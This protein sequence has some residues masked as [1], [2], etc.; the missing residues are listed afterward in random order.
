M[1][2]FTKYKG[3]ISNSGGDERGGIKSGKAGDQTGNEWVVRSWY[4]RP[5]DCVLRHPDT[6]VRELIAELAIEAANNN[7]IGY[8]QG[9][10][11]TYWEQLQKVGYRPKNITTPCEAD[12]SAGVIANTKSAGSILGM[13]KLRNIPATYT[14]NM[15]NAYKDAGFEVLTD[16]KY[17]TSADYLLPGDILLADKH[18]TA[19]NL[20][21]GSKAVA[22]NPNG[23]DIASYQASLDP[24][25]I[26]GDFI[27]VKATQGTGYINP[28]FEKHA[29][30]T[31]KS[32]KVLGLYHYANGSGVT[33]EVNF[34][35]QT[36]EK[37]IGKAFLCLDWENI[38]VAGENK[39][40]K[41]PG[42]AKQFMDEVR[43]RT[44]LTM[45][46][47]GSKDSCFNAMDWSAVKG[48][49]YPLWGAQYANYN[50]VNGYDRNPWES[51]RPWG[52]WGR[53]VAIHQYTS[54][55]R[56]PGY[57]GN[58]D[59]DLSHISISA[60]EGYTIAGTTSGV[61]SKPTGTLDRAQLLQMVAD[62]MGGKYGTNDERKKKL[63]GYYDQVQ[64]VIN[65]VKKT[66]VDQLADDVISGKFG[67]TPIREKVLGDKYDDV[68]KSVNAKLKK[69]KTISQLAKEVLE[70]KWGN[71]PERT[72]RLRAAG[73]DSVAVQKAVNNALGYKVA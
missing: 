3:K 15:R 62:T 52:A 23:I 28:Y 35:L 65:Y 33:G 38:A 26:A 47:Y 6:K 7:N 49:G 31:L 63:G 61:V 22:A 2:D 73:Y 5:W 41:N 60:L 14:G 17:L 13:P 42:Y 58:L 11:Q 68:Q 19:T 57:S 1:A 66:P 12:C 51:G 64:E 67:N 4:N 44:G 8:D 16:K 48:A 9:Q 69:Q 71:D 53:N 43:K 54:M 50:V 36:V 32:G 34:F 45:F 72:K 29:D 27:I 70:G 40:F 20:G 37:Y 10:R 39:Q 24:A 55:L 30:A 59:G 18:H 56:L 21:I 25:K 46:I